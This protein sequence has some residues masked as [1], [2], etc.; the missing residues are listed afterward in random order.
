MLDSLLLFLTKL[1]STL[2]DILPIIAIIFSFQWFVIRRPIPNVK[3][4]LLGFLLVLLGLTLFLL[5]LEQALFPLGK[6]MAE[7]LTQNITHGTD[8]SW[9]AY[10]WVY[11]F[12]ASMVFATTLAEPAL[13][14][15]AMKARDVSGG[16]ISIM[17]LR[18]AVAVGASFGAMLGTIR[19]V[20][21]IPIYYFIICCY[22]IIIIQTFFAP[23]SIIP[24]AYDSGGVTTS[25]VT[26]PLV[27]ALGLG[28]ATLIPG[29]NPLAD[30]FGMIAFVCMFPLMTVMGYAQLGLWL[31]KRRTKP[32]QTPS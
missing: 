27:T 30:G 32:M 28:L 1:F 11:L 22:F 16:S 17:G 21:G 26:V 6:L 5:G 18:V 12:A 3:R 13:L 7:Q 19:I 9:L 2:K 29:R 10:R 31:A 25:T 24:L 4:V 23:R 14:A 20:S 8:T 15:V